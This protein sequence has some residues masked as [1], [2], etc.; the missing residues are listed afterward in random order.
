MNK[1]IILLLLVLLLNTL[2]AGATELQDHY[3]EY[4]SS[5]NGDANISLS[6]LK[7]NTFNLRLAILN[8]ES[9][10]ELI[11]YEGK[12]V[13]NN[14]REILLFFDPIKSMGKNPKYLF[15]DGDGNKMPEDNNVE[16]IDDYTVKFNATERCIF[17]WNIRSCNK[18]ISRR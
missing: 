15:V 9:K 12:W 5:P 10:D 11:V 6:L 17:I 4:T 16:L 8:S 7:N 18:E 2:R 1:K 14:K 13:N 3:T